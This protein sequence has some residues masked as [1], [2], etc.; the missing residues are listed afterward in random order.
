VYVGNS[1]G[2]MQAAKAA[3]TTAIGYT[4]KYSS[5]QLKSAGADIII[6]DLREIKSVI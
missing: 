3:G 5:E 4:S 1:F 2:D 6:S